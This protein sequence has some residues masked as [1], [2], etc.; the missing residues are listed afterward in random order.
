MLQVGWQRLDVKQDVWQGLGVL[1][2]GWQELGTQAAW[3]PEEQLVWH[4]V[5]WGWVVLGGELVMSAG[6]LSW[7]LLYPGCGRPSNIEAQLLTSLWLLPLCFP[8]I[9]LSWGTLFWAVL[10]HKIVWL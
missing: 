5:A 2:D 6:C 9:L 10:L 4:M 8:N 7:Q 3:K 1:Q